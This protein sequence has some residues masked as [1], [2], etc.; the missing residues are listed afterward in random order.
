MKPTFATLMLHYPS[1][2]R[3]EVLY[4]Q[5]G[6]DDVVNN[7]VFQDTCAIRMS[8]ALLSAGITLT[9]STMTIHAGPLKGR[10]IETGQGRLSYDLKRMWGKPEVYTSE[11]AAKDGIGSRHGVVSFFRL[12]H[13]GIPTNGGHIDLVYPA[14]NGFQRCARSCYFDSA[15]V[16]FWPLH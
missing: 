7:P 16:W 15:E 5:I 3:R 12:R 14:G 4:K 2:E 11:Q 1:S 13:F 10:R 6:W 9:S 8:I